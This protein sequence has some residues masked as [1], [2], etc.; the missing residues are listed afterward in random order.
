V[1]VEATID[2]V[3]SPILKVTKVTAPAS[4][5]VFGAHWNGTLT[6][7]LPPTIDAIDAVDPADTAS[8]GYL[9]LSDFG[10][11]PVAGM[12][13]ES[14]VNFTVPSFV[15]GGEVYDR[16]GV[17]SNGYVVIGGGAAGDV[18]YEPPASFPDAATPNN[19]I[20]PFWTD[21]NPADGGAIRVGTLTDGTTSF[22]V[23]DWED[24]HAWSGGDGNSFQVWI[25]LGATESSWM[26]YGGALTPDT[27][28]GSLTGAENRDGTSGVSVADVD[29]DA[30]Y[31]LQ[32]SPPTAGGAVTF[33]YTVKGL[34]R[35]TWS[36]SA[37]LRSDAINTIPIEVTKIRVK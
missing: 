8:G 16:V 15:Y 17:V 21:L 37:T 22:L 7:A 35:G 28:A 29:T 24:I 19:V 34:L 26:T 25:Q 33:D 1:D 12:G 27:A 10:I 36:T 3:A 11:A 20:A 6:A 30:A 31:V 18:E 14:I 9:P 23:I 13:D 4:K 32:T 5:R 2:V